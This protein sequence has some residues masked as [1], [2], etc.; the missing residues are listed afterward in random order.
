MAGWLS[1]YIFY[2]RTNV[3]VHEAEVHVTTSNQNSQFDDSYLSAL[4]Q[5]LNDYEDE[6]SSLKDF[7]Q[8]LL[9]KTALVDNQKMMSSLLP[10]LRDKIKYMSKEDV[11]DKLTK[12]FPHEHQLENIKDYKGFATRL[13]DVAMQEDAIP[14][15]LNDADFV[16]D[17]TI[18]FYRNNGYIDSSSDSFPMS[19]FHKLYAN[20]TADPPL[21]KFMS[22]WKNLRTGELIKY[23]AHGVK[24]GHALDYTS[25][26]PP[27]GWQ[28]GKYQVSIYSLDDSLTM[29]AQKT[30]TITSIVDDG[31]E[32]VNTG[33][34]LK[35]I[36]N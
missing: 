30:Y 36:E 8:G 10:S 16:Q 28:K 17:I 4:E 25:A 27:A 13:A 15:N 9:S 21:T 29:L 24:G 23:Q 5:L 33:E 34:L 18:F 31:K 6:I 35:I 26:I 3:P 12:V 32:P 1:A 2:T 22:K 20:I 19:K 11:K 14:E 7:N